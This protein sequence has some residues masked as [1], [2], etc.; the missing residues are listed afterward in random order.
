MTFLVLM[1]FGFSIAALVVAARTRNSMQRLAEEVSRFE[2]E[3][4][5]I[6]R[7]TSAEPARP[8]SEAGS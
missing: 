4:A 8:T 6:V 1:A 7:S 3:M 2:R 5:R